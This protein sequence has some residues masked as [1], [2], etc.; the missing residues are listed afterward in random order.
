[1]AQEKNNGFYQSLLRV[2]K[3]LIIDTGKSSEIGTNGVTET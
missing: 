1:V 2:L 3:F